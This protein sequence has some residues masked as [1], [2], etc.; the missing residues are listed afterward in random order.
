MQLVSLNLDTL[1]II[2][3]FFTRNTCLR[4]VRYP[5]FHRVYILIFDD[6]EAEIA[7]I[8][9]LLFFDNIL[10]ISGSET[11]QKFFYRENAAMT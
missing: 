2:Y 8:Y 5:I 4:L 10:R 3:D 1:E 7:T 6:P 11:L 9:T